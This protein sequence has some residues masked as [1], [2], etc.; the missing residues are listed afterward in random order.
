MPAG[1]RF[2]GVNNHPL[3][4]CSGPTTK[5][6]RPLHA[7]RPAS[8]LASRY[9]CR[10]RSRDA[11]ADCL[12]SSRPPTSASPLK[13]PR[14]LTSSGHFLPG[15]GT[16][17]L[18]SVIIPCY[19]R[20][21]ILSE[22]IDSLLAQTYRNFEALV[23]DD[24]STDETRQV[25]SRYTDPRIRY[26]YRVNGGLSAA[27]NS[28]LDTARGE[29]IA[30]LDS[31]DLWHPWKLAAQIEIFR[32]HPE[33]GLIWSDMS[34][35]RDPGDVLAER[36][37]RTYYSAYESLDF[38]ARGRAGTLSDLGRDVPPGLA[39]CP[40]YVT[41]IFLD[42]FCG[43]LV[44]PSTAIA[45]RERLQQS[46]PFE[47]EVTGPGAEDYHFYFRVSAQG[48]VA[49]LDA[50]TT[51]F[52]LHPTQMSSSNGVHE[53]RGNLNVVLHWLRHHP[54]P[55]SPTL[56][57]DRLAK[58]HAWVGAEELLAGNARTATRHLWESF[59]LRSTQRTAT[60]LMVSL[61]PKDIAHILRRW[62]RAVHQMMKRQTVG[63]M[64]FLAHEQDMLCALI[65]LLQPDFAV[66]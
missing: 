47:P 19:N 58:S 15:P 5:A 56:I 44:H 11:H 12:G 66:I 37:L 4:R 65:S 24:G 60:L 43:N 25:I 38:D 13:P 23:I 17:G 26:F 10:E 63:V 48:A 28:G 8:G 59:R 42:M 57:R 50:P 41:D 55:L 34:T 1:R 32:R 36:H 27:R 49:F 51:L 30:F 20:A 35:F 53:A 62:K 52:R 14:T 46:G 6:W 22:T 31:D 39:Q 9:E 3:N 61:L 7:A 64:V 54:L 33:A 16:R 18:V 45:R 29:F 21:H 2:R 40:Y